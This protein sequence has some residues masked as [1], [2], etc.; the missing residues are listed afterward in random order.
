MNDIEY[1]ADRRNTRNKQKREKINQDSDKIEEHHIVGQINSE[2]T[3]PLCKSCHEYT[4]VSQNGYS[5]PLRKN[6]ELMA[7]ISLKGFLELT[8]KHFNELI[9]AK[10]TKLDNQK[11]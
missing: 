5:V 11:S 3:Y 2:E 10:I 7:L 9:E 6:K 1:L 4:S 8:L